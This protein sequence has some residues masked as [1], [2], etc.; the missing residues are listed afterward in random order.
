MCKI[1]QLPNDHRNLAYF[2]V[3]NIKIQWRYTC[4]PSLFTPR[5]RQY[6]VGITESLYAVANTMLCY[7]NKHRQS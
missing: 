1:L 3:T 6:F 4:Y 5:Q 7:T 2:T